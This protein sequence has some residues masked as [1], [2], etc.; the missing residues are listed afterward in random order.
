MKRKTAFAFVAWLVLFLISGSVHAQQ[1]HTYTDYDSLRIGDQFTYTIVFDS[2]YEN[3]VFPGEE[4]FEDE[5]EFLSRQRY[6]VTARRD[7]LVYSLQFFGTEDVTISRKEIRVTTADGDTTFYTTPVPLFFKTTLAS[8]EEEFRP[9]KP[10]FDFARS[11]WAYL[12]A[13]IILAI[14]AYLFY[15]WY[16]R[17]KS[18]PE[19]EPAPLPDPFI[20]PLKELDKKIAALPKVHALQTRE[21]YETYYVDLGDAIRY[22]LK[23]VY[24][25]HA[26]EMTTREIN[27]ALQRELAPSEIITITRKVLNEADLVKFANFHPDTQQAKSVLQKAKDFIETAGIVNYEQIKY[28]KYK[29]EVDHGFTNANPEYLKQLKK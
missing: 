19:K 18:A 13:L 2:E 27:E 14:A 24:Q 21:D 3:I 25:I 16:S 29:Y 8:E 1:V 22:Y 9:M 15:Q 11:W 4:N 28:M 12:L 20:N 7:S 17:R 10:I 5:L 26:M 23:R 6:Q